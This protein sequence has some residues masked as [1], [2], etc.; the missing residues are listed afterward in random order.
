MNVMV[1][2]FIIS[3][4][5]YDYSIFADLSTDIRTGRSAVIRSIILWLTKHTLHN[6][7]QCDMPNIDECAHIFM[8]NL[9]KSVIKGNYIYVE[10][11]ESNTATTFALWN[12]IPGTMQQ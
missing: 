1:N 5:S 10:R 4:I 7:I 12:C 6:V 8:A 2:I 9:C 11:T 3:I